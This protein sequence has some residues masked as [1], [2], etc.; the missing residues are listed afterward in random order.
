MRSRISSAVTT[1]S[2]CGVSVMAALV[3]VALVLRK[4][5]LPLT[6]PVG[7]SGAAALMLISPS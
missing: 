6:G 1:D 3:L 4:A 5:T 2:D 7:F